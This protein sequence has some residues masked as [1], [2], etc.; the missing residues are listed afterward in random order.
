[1]RPFQILFLL[2]LLIPLL[3]I[4]LLIKVGGIIGALPTVFMVVFTAVLGA[5]LLRI[6]GL[7]TL[8]RVRS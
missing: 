5:W 2:F 1:M 3:E 7:S 6:Q 4:Y 8:M